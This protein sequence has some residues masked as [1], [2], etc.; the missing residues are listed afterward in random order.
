MTP[1]HSAVLLPHQQSLDQPMDA[2]FPARKRRRPSPR[3][4][5]VGST[6]VKMVEVAGVES[7]AIDKNQLA[8]A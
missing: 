4:D 2:A 7:A 6:F 3:R 1:T 5:W 8:S